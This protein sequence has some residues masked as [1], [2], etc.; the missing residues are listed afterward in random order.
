VV[1]LSGAEHSH[2]TPEPRSDLEQMEQI[3]RD[4][5]RTCM[6]CSENLARTPRGGSASAFCLPQGWQLG[7]A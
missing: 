2:Y 1:Q 3:V 6:T 4:L 5:A 7:A